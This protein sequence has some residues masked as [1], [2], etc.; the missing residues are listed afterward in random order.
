M[1][2][3]RSLAGLRVGYAIG[4]AA[5]IEGLERIKNSF[6]SIPSIA[7]PRSAPGLR[8][9][10]GRGSTP[11]VARSWT[12]GTR[13]SAGSRGWGSRSCPRPRISSSR[14]THGMT[15]KDSPRPC[16]RA[17][18]WYVTSGCR[19]SISSCESPSA[20]RG[21]M[22]RA[23]RKPERDP[24][25]GLSGRQDSASNRR[26]SAATLSAGSPCLTYRRSRPLGSDVGTG[27]VIDGVV[28]AGGITRLLVEHLELLRQRLGAGK[29]GTQP[30]EA[31][32]R[33]PARIAP[34]TRGVSRS[35][36]TVTNSTCSRSASGPSCASLRPWSKGSS[37][38]RPD[39]A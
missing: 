14:D 21:A 30:Q 31:R 17:T 5:L 7:L 12:A 27:R 32:S 36:S 16:G 20:C 15:A 6:N 9:K 1:S 8:S 4:Q 29:I 26:M 10:T 3:S 37:D 39:T 24:A 22:S 38:R 34:A 2:K 25:A 13:W 11:A 33:R 19:V 23:G 35:G 28:R 18:S